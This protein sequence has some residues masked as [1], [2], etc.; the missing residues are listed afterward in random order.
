MMHPSPLINAPE[1]A[2]LISNPTQHIAIIDCS[3]DLTDTQ[4]GRQLYAQ[5]HIPGA[6]FLDLDDDLCS[7]KNGH[8]GRHPLPSR[9]QLTQHLQ[10]FGINHNT[11]VI[12]YD[13]SNSMFASHLWWLMLWLGHPQVRVLNGGLSAWKTHGGTLTPQTPPLPPQGNFQAHPPL[14]PTVDTA[15]ILKQLQSPELCLIDA[16]TPERYRGEVEP[17][18]PIAGHIPGAIN[19]DYNL[20]L[21]PTGAFKPTDQ[22]QKEWTQYLANTPIHTIVHHCG[23]GVS[24]CHNILAMAQIGLGITTLYPGSWSQWCANPAHPIATGYKA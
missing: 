1:L 7:P 3:F 16:R 20:N 24:A 22:L 23:S 10:T 17:L 13:Q 6:F 11:L 12:A 19:R 4:A 9:D 18:D 21:L 5:G 2:Q 15:Y 14:T 8:N